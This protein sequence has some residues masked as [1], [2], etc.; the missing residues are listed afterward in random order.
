ININPVPSPA[1][2]FDPLPAVCIN[3]GLVT[4]TAANE[5]K[6]VN[7]TGQY[8][9][10]GITPDGIFDP[11]IAGVG[12]HEIT[13]TFKGDKLNQGN[14]YCEDIKKQTI[15]VTSLPALEFEQ[16]FYILLDGAKP[17]NARSSG[18]EATYKWAP[19]V[20]LDRDD[21]LN[22]MIKGEVDRVYTLT[23][24]TPQGCVTSDTIRVY[25][26]DGLKVP[27]AFSPNGDG[28]NDVWNIG[29]IDSYPNATVQVF[30]RYGLVV[31]SSKGYA[32]PFDGK[33]QNK[34]LS[35]DTYYYVI[36]PGNG[37]SKKTGSLTIIK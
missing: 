13:Y 27:S 28:V 6:G 33:Y 9:G 22:P 25:V 32:E 35:I 17:F 19:A 24:T 3:A 11:R 12:T 16:D 20:G 31:F 7:G 21:V 34:D 2:V 18:P 36:D 10:L 8:S 14:V 37:K 4:I 26:L 15:T 23:A 30:N 5:T 1:V 29:Y